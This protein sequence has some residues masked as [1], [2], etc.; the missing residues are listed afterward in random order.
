M[1]L[2]LLIFASL[3]Y[4]AFAVRMI[5]RERKNGSSFEIGGFHS[6]AKFLISGGVPV[7]VTAT[8][9]YLF[10][11]VGGCIRCWRH[12]LPTNRLAQSTR[13]PTSRARDRCRLSKL[14]NS[15]APSSTAA[16]TCKISK[17][18]VRIDDVCALLK[19]TER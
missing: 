5:L 2:I 7:L 8:M 12:M 10:L 16:A 3:W 11:I 15:L 14:Q 18:R 19:P 17:L 6:L 4:I 9:S 13:S 1:L